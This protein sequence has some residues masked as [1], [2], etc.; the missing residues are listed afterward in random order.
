MD[1]LVRA[2][3]EVTRRIAGAALCAAVTC[4]AGLPGIAASAGATARPLQERDLRALVTLTNARISPDGRNVALIVRRADFEKNR[5][6]NEL[7]LVS[8]A[9]GMSRTLVRDRDDV[10][11]PRWSPRGD[12]LA[13]VATP[14]KEPNAEEDTS[15]QLY[16]L[17][18]DGGD[19]ARIT[20][21]KHG[22]AAYAWRP[23]GTGFAFLARD[24]SPDEK[25]IKA[26]D[27]WF[28]ITDDAWTARSAA[29]P[30][31]LWTIGADGKHLRRVTHGT[32]SLDGEPAFAPDGRSVFVSRRPR[33]STNRYRARDLVRIDVRNAHVRTIAR[34]SDGAVVT[35]DGRHLLYGADDPRASSQT[36]L[37]ESDLDGGRAHD[38]GAALD[39]DVQ[40]AVDAHGTI[41]AGA[42]DRTHERLF[43]IATNGTPRALPLGEVEINGDATAARDGTLAFVGTTPTRP[44]ELYVLAPGARAPRRLT[45]VNGRVAAHAFGRVRTIAWRTSD[46]FTAYGVLVAPPHAVAGRRSPLVVLI[47][48]GPT[49]TVTEGFSS[50]A[51]LMAARGWY[52][53]APNY[54]GS[55]D[56][57]RRWA[58]ATVP[59][60][61]SAPGRDIIEGVDA[62]ERLGIVDRSRI[63][64]SGWSEGGLLT[65]WL[66]AHDHR[67][68]AA[69][70][71]AAVNDWTG[72]ADMTDAKDFA[73]SFIGPSPWTS[74]SS[75]ALYDA[76]SPLS[77]AAQVRTPTLIMTDAGD[78]R[79]PTPLAYEFYHAV[80]AT[81]TPV[82]MV[83][84]PVNG[85]FPSD[86]LHREDVTHRW[87]G[88]F[89][90]HF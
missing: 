55:D 51:Q 49:A 58:Q 69:V 28:E 27:D 84:F 3:A 59:H 83:V 40:F 15:P 42:P 80:R 13:F 12:E 79:V 62:V 48:G 54:R 9:T 16:V 82:D 41:V 31:H 71:G 21:A 81:G 1:G 34:F 36:E 77:Y 11:T 32:W 6:R 88:W 33:A 70:S 35:G 19:A 89:A 10:D 87:I 57:G 24:D 5:Y 2:V 61:A 86:P 29:V 14:P 65:S 25:R 76:E 73:P 37:Y 38:V 20:A 4:A 22:V 7:V 44:S 46:G 74:A 63:G 67:W 17:P 50:Q 78:Q 75:R 64:V 43:A 45:G 52:V 47:H 30:T 23:D 26:H 90:A 53:F 56:A 18:M 8:T 60:I 39:R 66:I 72:Y 85:H 68:R